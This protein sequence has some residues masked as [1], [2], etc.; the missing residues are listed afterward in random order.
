MPKWTSVVT[1]LPMHETNAYTNANTDTDTTEMT[2]TNNTET[3]NC[4]DTDAVQTQE[5]Y[6]HHY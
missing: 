5:M 4:P 6:S 3:I 1:P 2:V